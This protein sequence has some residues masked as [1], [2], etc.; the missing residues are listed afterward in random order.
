MVVYAPDGAVFHEARNLVLTQ[1]NG[2]VPLKIGERAPTGVYR[3]VVLLRD[4][5]SRRFTKLE[6]QFGVK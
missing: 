5:V 4:L 1:G 6:R 3:V 2:V